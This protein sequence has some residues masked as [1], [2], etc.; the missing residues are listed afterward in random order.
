MY[1]NQTAHIA[2]VIRLKILVTLNDTTIDTSVCIQKTYHS[3]I[4]ACAVVIQELILLFELLESVTNF[5][6][7][8]SPR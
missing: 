6:L 8:S 4:E 3:L 5:C 7:P 2:S 1:S